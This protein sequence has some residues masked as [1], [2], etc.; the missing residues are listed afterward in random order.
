MLPRT[1]DGCLIS[2]ADGQMAHWVEY[3]EQL[4]TLDPTSGQ[5]KTA[6]L[7]MLDADLP[8]DAPCIN[9]KDAVAKL[10]DGKAVAISK[11]NSELLK[12]GSKTLIRGLH[13]VSTAAW[14]SDII[15]SDLK[16]KGCSS[17]LKNG[18]GDRQ[19]VNNHRAQR[20]KQS[21]CQC[22]GEAGPQSTAET[23]EILHFCVLVERLLWT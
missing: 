15:P 18:R 16:K 9:V 21:T 12:D 6:W 14:H 11:I 2:D 23:P 5:F 3:I 17:I 19:A 20:S 7:Q 8:I 10:R 1:T 13:A 4:F 22:A